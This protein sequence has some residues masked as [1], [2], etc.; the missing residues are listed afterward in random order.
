MKRALCCVFAAA[1]ASECGRGRTAP[2]D[3][4]QPPAAQAATGTAGSSEA[5]TLIGCL[6]RGADTNANVGTK[7]SD[8]PT[9]TDRPNA[10]PPEVQAP[11]ERFLLVDAKSD[12]AHSPV[13]AATS[14]TLQGDDLASHENQQVKISGRLINDPLAGRELSSGGGV[15]ERPRRVAVDKVETIAEKCSAK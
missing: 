15:T 1:L 2:G 11:T 6:Q 9:E 14:Y 3:T 8:S 5:V 4:A 10:R 13:A 12:T 7:G